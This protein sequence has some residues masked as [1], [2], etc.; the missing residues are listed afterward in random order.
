M[1]LATGTS[2]SVMEAPSFFT[3]TADPFASDA[4]SAVFVGEGETTTDTVG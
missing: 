2:W 4:V 3:L 1:K